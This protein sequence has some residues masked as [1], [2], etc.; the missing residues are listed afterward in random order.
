MILAFIIGH[1]CVP[2][3][4]L[5]LKA[6]AGNFNAYFLRIDTLTKCN[7]KECADDYPTFL[8]ASS[9]W[10]PLRLVMI[11][12]NKPA[13]T[14]GDDATLLKGTTWSPD[15]LVEKE[16][17]LEFD[18]TFGCSLGEV[19]DCNWTPSCLANTNGFWACWKTGVSDFSL[20]S[21]LSPANVTCLGMF[22]LSMRLHREKD[23]LLNW[24][25]SCC[26]WG[27]LLRF[28]SVS[29]SR[30]RSPMSSPYT[31]LAITLVNVSIVTYKQMWMQKGCSLVTFIGLTA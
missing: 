17:L 15:E 31:V 29:L 4:Q 13:E 25:R 9:R 27:R 5:L 14:V 22:G 21:I 28:C 20:S 8:W 18:G 30:G 11:Q 2:N 12:G 10:T 3:D 6:V 24:P 1:Y 26:I 19:L 23:A 16:T 7:S